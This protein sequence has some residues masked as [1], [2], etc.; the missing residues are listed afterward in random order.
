MLTGR[1]SLLR[2]IG[3]R[4]RF[5]PNRRSILS[6]AATSPSCSSIWEGDEKLKRDSAEERS[7]GDGDAAESVNCPVCGAR[8][9]GADNALIN[10]HVDD[11]LAPKA[12]K[13]K[14]SQVTLLQ[15]NFSRSKVRFDSSQP[16]N[17]QVNPSE[18][19]G[20]STSDAIHNLNGSEEYANNHSVYLGN[21]LSASH[22][23]NS[24]SKYPD[25]DKFVSP[26]LPSD[27]EGPKD[28]VDEY[29]DDYD[30][31]KVIIPTLIVGR[32]YGCREELDP[33]SR[34]CLS[35]DPE[36]V[37]DSNAIK[38][39]YVDCGYDSMLGYIPREL[40]QY[41]SPLIDN[42]HLSFEVNELY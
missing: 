19:D 27:V 22:E 13:R 33:Q 7:D 10:S 5:L 25:S 28:G 29:L 35:R 12:S 1:E 2:V 14:L 41:L 9:P 30:V 37:K 39:L 24:I 36:N 34:L 18:P 32:R 6:A 11:C 26:L 38:V 3:K 15:F 4:R 8:L 21:D 23:E 31:S 20:I 40:A 16:T 17:D 42:F